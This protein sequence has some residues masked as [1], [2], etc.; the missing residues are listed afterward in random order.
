MKKKVFTILLLLV[1]WTSYA[2]L[3]TGTL[4][5]GQKTDFSVPGSEKAAVPFKRITVEP[6]DTLLSITERINEGDVSIDQVMDDFTILN[7][8][9]DPNHLQI[10]KSYAFP[11]YDDQSQP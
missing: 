4:P 5:S 1:C 7:P 11:D 6:G 3:T 8:S 10:G 2:D 9:A